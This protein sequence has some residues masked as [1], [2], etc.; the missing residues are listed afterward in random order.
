MKLKDLLEMSNGVLIGNADLEMEIKNFSIDSRN[1][2]E[3]CVFVPLKGEKAD[4]H[5]YIES[6][7]NNGAVGTF[8]ARDS[9]VV[10]GKFFIKVNDVLSA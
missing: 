3:N 6:A 1:I 10:E 2:G 7:F 8:T 5:D 4:G 9:E